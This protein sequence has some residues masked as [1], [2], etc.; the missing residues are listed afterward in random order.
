[1]TCTRLN[2]IQDFINKIDFK[3]MQLQAIVKVA[4]EDSFFNRS[5]SVLAPYLSIVEEKVLEI[6]DLNNKIFDSLE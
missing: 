5:K 1:M 6:I 4:R 2:E 3:L